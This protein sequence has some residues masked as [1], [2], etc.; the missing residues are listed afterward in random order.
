MV[1]AKAPTYQTDSNPKAND[2]AR[3]AEQHPQVR[4]WSVC[5]TLVGRHTGNCLRDEQVHIA[6][7]SDTFTII[8]SPTCPVAGYANC[9]LAGPEPLQNSLAYRNLLPN[10]TFKPMAFTGPYKM[11]ATYVARPG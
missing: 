9:V 6:A 5:A 10:P 8:V 7:R 2:L 4:Y 11:T 3:T 1:T